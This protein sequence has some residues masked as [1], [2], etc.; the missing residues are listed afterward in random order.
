MRR[1]KPGEIKERLEV[2]ISERP[3]RGDLLPLLA[4]LL[5]GI[6]QLRKGATDAATTERL[7][8]DGRVEERDSNDEQ[9][10]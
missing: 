9:A 3:A 4:D 5:L 7:S 6:H 1:Q 10:S 8:A 2:R